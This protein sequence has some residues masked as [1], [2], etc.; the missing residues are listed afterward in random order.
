MVVSGQ[1]KVGKTLAINGVWGNMGV[2]FG[3]LLA[4]LLSDQFGW[5]ATFLLPGIVILATGVVYAIAGRATV[6][7]KTSTDGSGGADWA[8]F[9][10]LAILIGLITLLGGIVFHVTTVG[11]PKLFAERSGAESAL[12]QIGWMSAAVYAIAA[13]AQI[14][15]GL[16]LDRYSIKPVM[17]VVLAVQVPLLFALAMAGPTVTVWIALVA[18]L[19]VFGEIPIQ[20]AMVA[21]YV[22]DQWRSRVYALKYVISL[23]ASAIAVP[24]MSGLLDAT[25]S[26][27][28]VIYAIAAAAAVALLLAFALPSESRT[29]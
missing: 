10:R 9:R 23:G 25:G 29:R 17:L 8:L 26:M 24:M 7:D 4:G 21:R 1:P 2:A 19:F 18:M 20:D 22:A 28:A 12:T 13:F 3:P 6:I 14:P 5:R 27:T 11:L 15:V 16:S